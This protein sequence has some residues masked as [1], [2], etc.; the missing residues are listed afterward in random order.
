[1]T[2]IET[3]WMAF[4]TAALIG[5]GLFLLFKALQVWYSWT[6]TLVTTKNLEHY[7]RN[8]QQDLI[9]IRNDIHNLQ[10]KDKGST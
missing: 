4:G 7:N 10:P 9:Y 2:D 8:I 1:M 3:M 6:Q 5:W